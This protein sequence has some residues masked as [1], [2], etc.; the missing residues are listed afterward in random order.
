ME[1]K[2]MLKKLTT[3]LAVAVLSGTVSAN[4]QAA[5][6]TVKE[7]DTLSELSSVHNTSVKEI[8]NLNN[9]T[10]DVIK[11]GKILK[12]KQRKI[13]TVNQ[14]DTIWGIAK[15]YKVSVKQ[16][17]KWNKLSSNII[18]PGKK[19][20]IY[21]PI[22]LSKNKNDTSIKE[23]TKPKAQVPKKSTKV[24]TVKATAYT[25]SCTGCTGITKTG[26]NL[27]ANPNKKIIAVDPTVIPLGSKVYVEGYGKAI[28][29]D[30]GGAIKGKRIDVFIPTKKAA[31]KFGVKRLKVTILN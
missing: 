11:P 4:V 28:A 15:E 1:G 8:K 22:T 30:I 10:S 27:K 23:N 25:A 26:F 17:K 13:Y 29:A 19:L 18:R 2:R 6:V 24:I 12:L 14:G 20:L 31:I 21:N 3:L 9:L 7:G 5:T 16:V